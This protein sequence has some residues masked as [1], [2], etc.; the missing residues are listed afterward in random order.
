[1]NQWKGYF[2]ALAIFAPALFNGCATFG[3]RYEETADKI[4]EAIYKATVRYCE[5][6]DPAA[7]ERL[8]ARLAE[9]SAAGAG[10][11]LTVIC[12]E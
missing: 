4:A 12:S 11:K 3:P 1:M 5:E 6:T 8:K 2:L 7:R 10:H 9:L